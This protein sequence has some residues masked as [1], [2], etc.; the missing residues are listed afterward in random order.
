MKRQGKIGSHIREETKDIK[1]PDV[2]RVS[3]VQKS[4][5]SKAEMDERI[6]QCIN[7]IQEKYSL[8][9]C[10]LIVGDLN[11]IPIPLQIMYFSRE[12]NDKLTVFNLDYNYC[13]Y[14]NNQLDAYEFMCALDI[15]LTTLVSEFAEITEM[16]LTG[17]IERKENCYEG[18]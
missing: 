1:N 18:T 12:E 15:L 7:E 2:P 6:K 4:T 17:S 13:M 8:E 3:M 16:F 9:N 14:K 5:A 11:K 10:L